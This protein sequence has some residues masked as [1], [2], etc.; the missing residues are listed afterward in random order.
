MGDPLLPPLTDQQPIVDKDGVPTL[1]F[2]R[3]MQQ[4][5]AGENIA[6]SNGVVSSSAVWGSIT[7]TLTAQVDLE[8]ALNTKINYLDFTN[9]GFD[10][11]KINFFEFGGPAPSTPGPGGLFSFGADDTGSG[12]PYMVWS[13][14]DGV[15]LMIVGSYTANSRFA[16]DGSKSYEFSR[17]PYVGTY[18]IFYEGNLTFGSGLTYNAGTGV[19][20]A[21]GGGGGGGFENTITIPAA[22]NFTL[23]N[24]AGGTNA[25]TMGDYG[26]GVFLLQNATPGATGQIRFARHN[27]VTAGQAF[28]MTAR[29]TSIDPSQPY[30]QA[31]QAS[32]ILRNSANGRMILFGNGNA[33]VTGYVQIFS[34]YTSGQ[35]GQYT[36][37]SVMYQFPWKQITSDGTNL[38]FYVSKD[39]YYWVPGAAGTTIANYLVALD[40]VGIGMQS[41][42]NI[43]TPHGTLCQSFT[44]V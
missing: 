30:A 21:S 37:F 27:T 2:Q 13:N 20:S 29:M 35:L 25:A 7:G 42:P 3:F 33:D 38:K 5:I 34:G 32:L 39:G 12:Q 28:T 19:L 24:G 4:L 17:Q 9:I 43:T 36:A 31:Q 8:D 11:T 40:E 16:L 6:V 26:K 23:L 44:F 22:A 41:I 10:G 1:Y 18:K 15:N 14:A